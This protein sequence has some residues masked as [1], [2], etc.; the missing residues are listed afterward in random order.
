MKRLVVFA[1]GEGSNAENI[2]N[3]FL[4]FST[5]KVVFFCTNDK[6]ANVVNRA[7]KLRLPLIYITKK[8]LLDFSELKRTLQKHKVDFIILAGFLLKIPL[9][10]I[11]TYPKKIINLHPS[12]LPKYGGRGMYG[13]NVHLAVLK[14]KEKRTGITIHFVNQ[15]YD[16]GEVITQKKCIVA[17]NESVQSL[18]KKI[19]KLEFK[20]FPE[21][22]EKII[23]N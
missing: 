22:I 15:N 21:T 4:N 23:L 1:S 8:E 9:E 19:K 10:M 12:L 18:E 17:K 2:Y 7:K 3:Y 11:N 20:Y 6:T 14:N 13:K 16:E 5:V